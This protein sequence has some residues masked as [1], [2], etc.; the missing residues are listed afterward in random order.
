MRPPKQTVDKA[1]SNGSIDRA[2]ERLSAAYLLSCEAN[3]LVDEAAEILKENGLLLGEIKQLHNNFMT[4]ASRYFREFAD[5]IKISGKSMEFFADLED[6]DK[7]FRKWSKLSK[8]TED[9]V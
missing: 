6:F 7:V 5:M 8:E 3:N 9:R 2:S 1:R 4:A